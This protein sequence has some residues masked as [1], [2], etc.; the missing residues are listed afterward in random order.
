MSSSIKPKVLLFPF[1][2]TSQD[3]QGQD[4]VLRFKQGTTGF[5]IYYRELTTADL[6]DVLP[7]CLKFKTSMTNLG[8]TQAQL[9]QTMQRQFVRTLSQVLGIVWQQ[10]LVDFPPAD[11]SVEAFDQLLRHFIAAHADEEDRQELANQLRAIHRPRWLS[12]TNYMYQ[13]R[14][15]CSYIEWLPGTTPALTDDEMKAAFFNGFPES[16][17]RDWNK[18]KGTLTNYTLVEISRFM[19]RLERDATHVALQNEIKQKE[20]ARQK[21]KRNNTD[22]HNRSSRVRTTQQKKVMN[23]DPCPVH[24]GTH[25]W[26]ECKANHYNDHRNQ[27]RNDRKGEKTKEN[28]KA[29]S[30]MEIDQTMMA[31]QNVPDNSQDNFFEEESFSECTS[32]YHTE[33][34]FSHC[35]DNV[36]NLEM[37]YFD[38][39]SASEAFSSLIDS[40]KTPES[41]I[42]N[43]FDN[44]S[45]HLRPVSLIEIKEMQRTTVRLE[46]LKVLFDSGADRTFINRRCLPK[47]INSSRHKTTAFNTINGVQNIQQ[48]IQFSQFKLPEFSPSRTV[49]ANFKALVFDQ[50]D[51]PYDV[52]FGLD[53]LCLLGIDI[54]TSTLTV[55]WRNKIIPFHPRGLIENNS[56]QAIYASFSDDPL[57]QTQFDS[58]TD[59][60]KQVHR[61]IMPNT[62]DKVDTDRI[63]SEQSHLTQS[64]RDDLAKL[65]RKYTKLFSGKLG[66]YPKK[67]LHFEL[68]DNAKPFHSRPYTVPFH[69]RELFKNEL[70]RLVKIGVLVKCGASE[71][72]APTFI[73]PKKDNKVRWVSDFRGLNK[74]I[75]RKVYN[76][77]KIQDIIR[78]RFGYRFFTKLDLNMCFYTYALDDESSKLCTICTP[79]GNYRYNVAPMGV[80]QSPDFAQEIIEDLFR[81]ISD[82][83]EAYIDDIG[84]FSNNWEHHINLLEKVLTRLQ[85]NNFTVNPAKCEWAIQ[86]TDFLGHWMTPTGIK[87]WK[88]KID[89]ILR[90]RRPTTTKELRS[91]IGAVSFYRDFYRRRSHILAPLTAQVSK[92]QLVWTPECQTAFD[93]MKALLAKDAFLRYPNP[94]NTFTSIVMPATVNLAVSLCNMTLRS[95]TTAVNSTRHNAIIPPEKKNYSPLSKLSVSIDPYSMVAETSMSTQTIKT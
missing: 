29:T 59:Y 5:E 57:D 24:G 64:Q 13:F 51:G 86:E 45:K 49:N 44:L 15:R 85:D 9:G 55:H 54:H 34:A 19:R 81:D 70:D 61:N 52:I 68:I 84:C 26:G 23:S 60:L 43:T 6:K 21:R 32:I 46:P 17:K 11:T 25:K 69:H 65:F 82:D 79:Y 50:K 8:L 41:I 35:S 48:C 91:F 27:Q 36:F 33:N 88:K 7:H 1:I 20:E 95:H 58:M 2:S 90:L 37:E 73:V 89:P 18:S 80:K 71:W 77:P 76:L 63:A 78:R 74:M 56:T 38:C 40:V 39:S 83:T 12:S 62:Y 3:N 28:A 66:V 30:E 47:G 22:D 72:L 67:K 42:K 53:A 31:A 16:W 87:P 14:E 4:K 75:K 92:K 93:Q 94:T 10:I